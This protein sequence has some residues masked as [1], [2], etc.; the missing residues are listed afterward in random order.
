[1]MANGM[2]RA[3]G[4]AVQAYGGHSPDVDILVKVFAVQVP[5]AVCALHVRRDCNLAVC[6]GGGGGARGRDDDDLEGQFSVITHE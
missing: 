5:L 1:M 3:H 2:H 4:Q 6:L